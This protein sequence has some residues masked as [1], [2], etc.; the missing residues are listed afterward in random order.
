MLSNIIKEIDFRFFNENKIFSPWEIEFR[1]LNISSSGGEAYKGLVR[2]FVTYCNRNKLK[3]PKAP[4]FFQKDHFGVHV[5]FYG[6]TSKDI[7]NINRKTSISFIAED[8]DGTFV[9]FST[10]PNSPKGEEVFAVRLNDSSVEFKIEWDILSYIEDAKITSIRGWAFNSKL[11][12]K[13]LDAQL[14]DNGKLKKEFQASIFRGDVQDSLGMLVPHSGFE[15]HIGISSGLVSRQLILKDSNISLLTKPLIYASPGYISNFIK[16]LSRKVNK[17]EADSAIE[18]DYINALSGLFTVNLYENFIR[19]N[20]GRF[21]YQLGSFCYSKNLSVIIPVYDG[22]SQTVRC[23]E[24]VLNSKTIYNLEILIGYDAGPDARLERF[25]A[26]ISDERV[27]KI[28]NKENLGFVQN[29]NNLLSNKTN[30]DFLLLNADT[31]VSDHVIDRLYGILNQNRNFGSISPISNNA[32]IFT[33]SNLDL[34]DL[35]NINIEIH[36]F[37]ELVTVPVSHGFC[38]MINGDIYEKIGGFGKEWGKGY[39]EEVDWCLKSAN[40]LGVLHGCYT[41]VFVYHEGSVSFGQEM[42]IEGERRA[43]EL[44]EKKYPGFNSKIQSYV[45]EGALNQAKINLDLSIRSSKDTHLFISHSFGGGIETYLNTKYVELKK[46]GKDY[47]NLKVVTFADLQYWQV[48]GSFYTDRYFE[49]GDI[50]GLIK[51][52]EKRNLTSISVEHMGNASANEIYELLK[53]LNKSYSLMLHDFSWVC[54]KINLVDQLGRY[55]NLRESTTCE[56]C[57]E[58]SNLPSPSAISFPKLGT[59]A[60]LRK[61]SYKIIKGST[62][63]EAPSI[64]TRQIYLKAFPDID[65]KVKAHHRERPFKQREKSYASSKVVAILG[66]ISDVKGLYKYKDL[67]DYMERNYPNVTIVFFGYTSNDE[68]FSQNKNVKITG[69]YSGREDLLKLIDIYDPSICLHFS[70]WPE[71]FSYTLSESLS[72]G[73]YPF[74]FKIGAVNDRLTKCK[75]GQG[76]SVDEDVS[77]VAKAIY[78]FIK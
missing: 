8:K 56:L 9:Y 10:V 54:P 27:L 19:K 3:K 7:I 75:L 24:S 31:V 18:R 65:V 34:T 15:I 22:F 26:E 20:Y 2:D 40:E 32:T 42:R 44:L 28:F 70:I 50:A 25:I 1:Y 71:T 62:V 38:M 52:L 66:A 74:Y 72:L 68:L 48:S 41:G 67:A 21:N 59:V 45:Y 13:P 60:S 58:K 33:H 39:G 63:V 37:G 43:G 76:F 73:L 77:L 6:I 5:Y 17:I 55:C 14:F 30:K 46:S 53:L 35:N 23:I 61:V 78:D 11:H 16:K 12:Q 69:K 49:I 4:I 51:W 36:N 47:I 29:V 57:V 64:S